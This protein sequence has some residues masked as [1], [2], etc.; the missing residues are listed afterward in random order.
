LPL[1]ILFFE[2]EAMR[3]NGLKIVSKLKKCAALKQS[4]K[5]WLRE[6]AHEKQTLNALPH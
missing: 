2:T 5:R 6:L 1:L 4:N 3:L